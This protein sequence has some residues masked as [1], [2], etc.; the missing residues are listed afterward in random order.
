MHSTSS[1]TSSL[2]D[3][4]PAPSAKREAVEPLVNNIII[5]ISYCC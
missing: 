1:D 4:K 5:I 3:A 2:C